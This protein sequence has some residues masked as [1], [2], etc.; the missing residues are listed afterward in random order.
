MLI[1]VSNELVTSERD[2]NVACSTWKQTQVTL[3]RHKLNWYEQ[4]Y[5]SKYIRECSASVGEE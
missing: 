4:R 1:A 2:S 5:L 3:G